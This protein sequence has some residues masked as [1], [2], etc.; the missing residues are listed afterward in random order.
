MKILITESLEE[1][2]IKLYLKA[3][4]LK[5]FQLIGKEDNKDVRTNIDTTVPD[6][7]V[8][9]FETPTVTYYLFEYTP[10]EAA[11]KAFMLSQ[12]KGFKTGIQPIYHEKQM[13]I[14]AAS[15]DGYLNSNNGNTQFEW[16][17]ISIQLEIST[18]HRNLF[19]AYGK[20]QANHII[21]KLKINI[22]N[23]YFRINEKVFDLNDFD[24]QRELIPLV[25]K[26]ALD[27]LLNKE[28]QQAPARLEFLTNA[29][30]ERIY[31][32]MKNTLGFIRMKGLGNHS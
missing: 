25:E 2:I 20:E 24:N 32:D 21:Q 27:F 23:K 18:E 19:T 7:Q 30:S 4:I 14:N 11:R 5:L 28:C 1:L 29:K 22:R 6:L 15:F 13:I 9:F 31:I 3:S 16:I 10:T 8:N 26:N 12:I 17:I